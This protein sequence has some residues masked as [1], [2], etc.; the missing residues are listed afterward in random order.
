MKV[1]YCLLDVLDADF[2]SSEITMG[3]F[4]HVIEPP[5]VNL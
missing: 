1:I 5:Q 2:G 4:D 3:R